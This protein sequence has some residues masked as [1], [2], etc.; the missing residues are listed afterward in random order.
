MD[1]VEKIEF[2]T[3]SEMLASFAPGK[4]LLTPRGKYLFRG[5]AME[6]WTLLPS[7]LRDGVVNDFLKGCGAGRNPP[8]STVLQKLNGSIEAFTN[9]NA[10]A[11]HSSLS[12]PEDSQFHRNAKLNQSITG[13]LTP[14]DFPAPIQRSQYAMA[15][16]HG[17]PTVLLDWSYDP[18]VA[19]YFAALTRIQLALDGVT[20][21]TGLSVWVF[22]PE[23]AEVYFKEKKQ[24]VELVTA[25]YDANPYLSAQCGL[26]TLLQWKS[27]LAPKEVLPLEKII[28]GN[29]TGMTEP[30]LYHLTLPASEIPYIAMGLLDYGYTEAKI[31]PGFYSLVPTMKERQRVTDAFSL[32]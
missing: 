20:S 25:P 16:H 4:A 18:L 5:H 30:V 7:A 26:F 28:A 1:V 15:Q 10:L 6:D 13:Q 29:V 14:G 12:L 21:E 27:D 2:E 11:I 9:F 31:K 19:C 8:Y 24:W 23:A 32:F 17:V 22:N 3:A